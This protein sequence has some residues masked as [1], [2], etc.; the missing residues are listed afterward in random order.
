MLWCF[1]K[2]LNCPPL[3]SISTNL[4]LISWK[5][6]IRVKIMSKEK[7]DMFWLDIFILFR[8]YR[9]LKVR[10][11]TILSLFYNQTDFCLVIQIPRIGKEYFFW[12]HSKINRKFVA[13]IILRWKERERSM[14]AWGQTAPKAD[15]C[16]LNLRICIEK[17]FAGVSH[18]RYGQLGNARKWTSFILLPEVYLFILFL[19]E[20]S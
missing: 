1:R 13:N 10:L 4:S 20:I 2:T 17:P 15:L 3:M 8:F 7:N 5:K 12:L 6:C 19:L 11:Y 9:N 14:L 16:I 18:I